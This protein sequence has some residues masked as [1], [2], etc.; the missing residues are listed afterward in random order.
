MESVDLPD[1]FRRHSLRSWRA[2]SIHVLHP[3][4]VIKTASTSHPFASKAKIM[5]SS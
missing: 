3:V 5:S 4:L 1:E 2:V